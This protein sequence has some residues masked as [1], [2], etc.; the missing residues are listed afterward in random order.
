MV[1][2]HQAFGDTSDDYGRFRVN[3]IYPSFNGDHDV[4]HELGFQF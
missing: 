1:F 3:A 2:R 4:I